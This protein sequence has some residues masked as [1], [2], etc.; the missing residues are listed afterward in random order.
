M[1]LKSRVDE[2][3]PPTPMLTPPMSAATPLSVG[4][5]VSPDSVPASFWDDYDYDDAGID[6]D[7]I[8]PPIFDPAAALKVR[9]QPCLSLTR[10]D[11]TFSWCAFSV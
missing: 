1:K 11:A 4:P 5:S 9:K 6:S 10:A 3:Y 7:L 8:S 2:E